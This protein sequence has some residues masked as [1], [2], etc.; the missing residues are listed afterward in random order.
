MNYTEDYG[1]L[2]DSNYIYKGKKIISHY[3]H[4]GLLLINFNNVVPV[5]LVIADFENLVMLRGNIQNLDILI[6][7]K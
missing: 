6:E 1:I 4:A 3:V 7:I 2:L 5:F